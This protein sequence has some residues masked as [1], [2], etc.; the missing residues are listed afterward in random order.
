VDDPEKKKDLFLSKIKTEKTGLWKTN[1]GL[2][3]SVFSV[4]IKYISWIER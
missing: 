4:I 3:S 2:T 1:H